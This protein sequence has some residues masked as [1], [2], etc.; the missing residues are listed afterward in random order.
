M[1]ERIQNIED[2][3]LVGTLAIH[4]EIE[5]W[6]REGLSGLNTQPLAV[7]VGKQFDFD[8]AE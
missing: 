3:K 1:N 2:P 6:K 8:K 5:N 4:P 7:N